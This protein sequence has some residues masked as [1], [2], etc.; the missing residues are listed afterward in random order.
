MRRAILLAV[1]SLLLDGCN[2]AQ[3]GTPDPTNPVHCIAAFN[4]GAF[5]FSRK[6]RQPEGIA[7]RLAQARFEYGKLM[8]SGRSEA[9]IR[10]QGLAFTKAYASNEK[11]MNELSRACIAAQKADPK[12]LN[13]K[14]KL[15]EWGRSVEPGYYR[16]TR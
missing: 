6:P 12:F 8:E 13:Q 11:V 5:L 1:A 3:A 15:L 2:K 16:G 7:V 10:S 14:W 4:W 9:E